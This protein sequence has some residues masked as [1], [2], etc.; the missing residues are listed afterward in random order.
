MF[1]ARETNSIGED[2]RTE[3]FVGLLA[4]TI[5][6]ISVFSLKVISFVCFNICILSFDNTMLVSCRNKNVCIMRAEYP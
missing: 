1:K 5:I 2:G 3:E 4:E 6:N